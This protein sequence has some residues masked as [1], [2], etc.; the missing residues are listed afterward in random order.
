M[1]KEGDRDRQDGGGGRGEG[2]VLRVV[3]HWRK[4]RIKL[5]AFR[6]KNARLFKEWQVSLAVAPTNRTKRAPPFVLI[7]PTTLWRP[8]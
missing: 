5:R 3:P 7:F 4:I 2:D 8:G 6:G 1:K